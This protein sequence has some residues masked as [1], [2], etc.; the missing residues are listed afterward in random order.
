MKVS[1]ENLQR[2][3]VQRIGSLRK[4]LFPALMMLALLFTRSGLNAQNNISVR[5]KI[6]NED[7]QPVQRASITVK[8]SSAGATA[9]DNGEFVINAPSD[10]TLVISAINHATLE[11]A[12]NNN[13]ALEVKLSSLQKTETEVIVVGYGTQRKRDVTGAIVKVNSDVLLQTPS[14]NRS[15]ERRVGKE[16][17]D[18]QETTNGAKVRAGRPPES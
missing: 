8:G 11:V 16:D 12:I 14:H 9:D 1:K 17:R 15:E 4:L 5:G 6:T 10:G 3:C 13:T 18:R 7:N 2:T